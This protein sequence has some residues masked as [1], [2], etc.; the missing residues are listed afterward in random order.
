MRYR[1]VDYMYEPLRVQSGPAS[2]LR[3]VPLGVAGARVGFL[4]ERSRM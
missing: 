3:P 4:A 1:T 2:P